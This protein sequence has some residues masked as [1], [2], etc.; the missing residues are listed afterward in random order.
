KCPIPIRNVNGILTCLPQGS[1]ADSC[2]G[3][4]VDSNKILKCQCKNAQGDWAFDISHTP[5]TPIIGQVDL[6][7]C[8]TF[9]IFNENGYLNC[10]P[11]GPY[12][13]ACRGCK[14]N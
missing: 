4:K 11:E 13:N 10:L 1:Y 7:K 2:T 3:C 8:G 6:K 9:D 5:A 12:R 14:I